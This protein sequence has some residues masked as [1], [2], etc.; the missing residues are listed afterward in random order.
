MYNS[1]VLMNRVGLIL[2]ANLR[3]FFRNPI[4]FR[5]HIMPNSF[6]DL[7]WILLGHSQF[8]KDVLLNHSLRSASSCRER[9]AIIL[10]K[11]HGILGVIKRTNLVHYN[12]VASAPQVCIYLKTQLSV[13]IALFSRVAF[14]NLLQKSRYSFPIGRFSGCPLLLWQGLLARIHDDLYNEPAIRVCPLLFHV[15]PSIP[16]FLIARWLLWL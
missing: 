9:I 4:E 7:L 5:C 2:V 8:R 3:D 11:S 1:N 12:L 16:P 13:A 10:I 15:R 14:L 6:T